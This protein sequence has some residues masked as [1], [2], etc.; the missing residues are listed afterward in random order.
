MV[1]V[2]RRTIASRDPT[3]APVALIGASIAVAFIVLATLFDELS[4]PHPVYIFLYM[5]GLVTVL[6]R[7]ERPRPQP[8]PIPAVPYI[9]LEPPE[10][11]PAVAAQA[12]AVPVR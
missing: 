10:P 7:E 11:V 6:L 5:I 12:P 4:F 8:P 9:P 3:A 1:A 2:C